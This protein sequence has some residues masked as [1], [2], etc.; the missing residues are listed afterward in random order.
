MGGP[1]WPRARTGEALPN[2][3]PKVIS[4]AAAA[5]SALMNDRTS[6]RIVLKWSLPS[7]CQKLVSK[8][9]HC[10]AMAASRKLRD[11]AEIE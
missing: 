3:E 4:S 10:M 11:T 8:I 9:D 2:S 5:K 1:E 6:S 7:M